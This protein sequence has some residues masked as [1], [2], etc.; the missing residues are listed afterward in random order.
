MHQG[1]DSE[2]LA[3]HTSNL[4]WGSTSR[5][6]A[7]V[8]EG[9]AGEVS[10]DGA[11]ILQAVRLVPAFSGERSSLRSRRSSL[12]SSRTRFSSHFSAAFSLAR[13]SSWSMDILLCQR[14]SGGPSIGIESG[15]EARYGGRLPCA[16]T[17]CS[18]LTPKTSLSPA[19][20]SH[21]KEEVVE[22]AGRMKSS[23]LGFWLFWIVE[24]VAMTVTLY[25]AW[26]VWRP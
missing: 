20:S 25:A 21:P 18:L 14:A 9:E 11:A 3:A 19:R 4:R 16:M 5:T 12:A 2:R 24:S 15:K 23:R 6:H 22:L 17:K 13:S 7:Q 10:R 8:V 26:H 1:R